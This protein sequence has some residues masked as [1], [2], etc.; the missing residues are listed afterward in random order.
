MHRS[1]ELTDRIS[2]RTEAAEDQQMP[3]ESKQDLHRRSPH[4]SA[5]PWT[6]LQTRK[7]FNAWS[8][9]LSRQATTIAPT[10]RAVRVFIRASIPT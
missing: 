3:G 4:V 1:G 6:A 8:A 5:H 7:S 9:T 2:D 10:H